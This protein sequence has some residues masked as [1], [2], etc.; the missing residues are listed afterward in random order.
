M[1]TWYE[2]LVYRAELSCDYA[3]EEVPPTAT[4]PPVSATKSR[5]AR[6]PA[7][8]MLVPSPFERLRV[9]EID[10]ST[11]GVPTV[12]ARKAKNLNSAPNATLIDVWFFSFY[13]G[14][15]GTVPLGDIVHLIPPQRLPTVPDDDPPRI[16]QYVTP[17][18]KFKRVCLRKGVFPDVGVARLAYIMMARWHFL[19]Y[20][21]CVIGSWLL[22]IPRYIRRAWRA[23]KRSKRPL[24][25]RRRRTRNNSR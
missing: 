25:A 19:V 13:V 1:S 20:T 14:T 15:N 5:T 24:R 11:P 23:Y 22:P 4:T 21:L 2:P 8:S 7:K 6:A 18:L 10:W 3:V 17:K 16:W 9:P 12:K